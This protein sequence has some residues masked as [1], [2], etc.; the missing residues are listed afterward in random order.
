[1]MNL[2]ANMDLKN[3]RINNLAKAKNDFEFCCP[4][5][6]DGGISDGGI[7]DG[8][9][10]NRNVALAHSHKDNFNNWALAQQIKTNNIIF[11]MPP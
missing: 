4:P 11:N 5:S 2:L 3:I 10:L 8:G 6:K 1:M 9:N 7:S